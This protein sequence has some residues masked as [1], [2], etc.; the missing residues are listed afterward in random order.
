MKRARRGALLLVL[1]G[2]GGHVRQN[3]ADQTGGVDGVAGAGE[4]GGASGVLPVTDAGAWDRALDSE[5]GTDR[6]VVVGDAGAPPTKRSIIVS[7]TRRCLDDNYCFGMSCYAPLELE[8]S[9]CLSGCQS[10]VD[11]GP[12]GVCLG[13]AELEPGCFQPCD[14][15]FDCEYGFDCFDFANAQQSLVCFPTT[16]A[17]EWER[18][19]R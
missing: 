9:V 17:A 18:N 16:W 10:D 7:G 11:C 14:T 5:G 19:R 15:P 8:E 3:R 2:C 6:A 1:V 4:S 13:S 12:T